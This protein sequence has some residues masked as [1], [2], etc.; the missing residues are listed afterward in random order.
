META[1]AEN[2]ETIVENEAPQII[3]EGPTLPQ[4]LNDDFV[5]QFERGI[6]TYKKFVAA[7]FRLTRESHWINHSKDRDKPKYSLQGPGAEALMNPLGISYEAPIT[8]QTPLE[9][10]G[11]AYWVEGYFES[12]TL[13]RRGYY[14]GYCDSRDPFF[15]ARP[16]WKPETGHG[17]VRKAATTNL[18]VN[19]VTR[20]A[21]IRDP[22]P[23]ML[24]SAG[25][26]PEKIMHIDYSGS[27]RTPTESNETISE[28]QLKRL[29]AIAKN[30]SVD[31]DGVAIIMKRSGYT[32]IDD[33]RRK[34]YDKICRSI[35]TRDITADEHRAYLASKDTP[36]QAAQ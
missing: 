23:E 30:N 1:Q 13:N 15:N 3:E 32:K 14:V 24:K 31:E 11:Y 4:I 16:G 22:D 25:L 36:K 29:W 9:N 7:C 35:E 6:A 2:R 10:G 19:A 21:G 17:D 33:I 28:A 18:V 34:D 27:G 20:L 5:A 26:N 8:K 12:K